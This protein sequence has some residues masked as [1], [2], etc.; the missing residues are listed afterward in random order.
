MARLQ[1]HSFRICAEMHAQQGKVPQV[2]VLPYRHCPVIPVRP[3]FSMAAMDLVENSRSLTCLCNTVSFL[4]ISAAPCFLR[5]PVKGN[6]R[7]C[8]QAQGLK[9]GSICADTGCSIM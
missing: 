3:P 5:E 6:G 2:R 8:N 7:D 4:C 1:I 9:N